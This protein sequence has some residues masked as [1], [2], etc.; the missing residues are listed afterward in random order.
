MQKNLNKPI[1]T[2]SIGFEFNEYDEAKYA[3]KISKYLQTDHYE[4]YVSAKECLE[5]VP[6]VSAIYGEPFADSSQI[7]TVI[8]C[9]KAK[10]KLLFVNR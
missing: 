5:I 6:K 3:K 1:K 2:F 10:K 7:P 9:Q 4:T 8:L